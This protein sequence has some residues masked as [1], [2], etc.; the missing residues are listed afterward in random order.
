MATSQKT[1][2]EIFAAKAL[3]SQ[4]KKELTGNILPY[5]SGKMLNPSG[6]F[7]G[8]ITGTEELGVA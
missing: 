3:A 4:A 5:W 1:P 7:Y 8:R 6:G 2:A